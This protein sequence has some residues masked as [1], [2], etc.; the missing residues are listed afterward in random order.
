MKQQ[1]FFFKT[2]ANS[3]KNPF[4]ARELE[5]GFAECTV[6][7]VDVVKDILN[8]SLGRQFQALRRQGRAILGGR[9]AALARPRFAWSTV[10]DRLPQDLRAHLTPTVV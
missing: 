2:G 8:A 7:V 6:R 1:I 3:Q 4:I 5:R 10:G 9:G